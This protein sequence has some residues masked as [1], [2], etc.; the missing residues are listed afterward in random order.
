MSEE[1]TEWLNKQKSKS[2][3]QWSKS[4]RQGCS[5]DSFLQEN[6]EKMDKT[7]WNTKKFV[8]ELASK[9]IIK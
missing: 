7:E 1:S 8:R 9:N 6:T 3:L 4:N 5:S 2:N